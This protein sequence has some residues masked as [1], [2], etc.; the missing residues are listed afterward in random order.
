MMRKAVWPAL[1]WTAAVC[2]PALAQ[3][4]R[5]ESLVVNVEVPVRVF[6][7]SSFI[8]S[9]TAADFEVY[10]NGVPQ[11][12]EAIYMVKKRTI[13]RREEETKFKPD[14]VRNF[15]LLFEITDYVPRLDDALRYFVFDIL[16][17]GDNIILVTPLKTYRMLSEAIAAK[18][19]EDLLAQFQGILRRD[20]A[21]GT[22]EFRNIVQELERLSRALSQQVAITQQVVISPPGTNPEIPQRMDGL[23]SPE[24]EGRTIDDLLQRYSM[25][26]TQLDTIRALDPQKALDLAKHLKGVEGQKNVFLF[27][28]REFIPK[29]DPK[30]LYQYMELYQD[31]PDLQHKITELFEFY[32]RELTFNPDLIKKSFA[33]AAVSVHF[34]FLTPAPEIVTGVRLEEHSDDVYAAFREIARASGGF[35][36]SS[37][38]PALLMKSAVESSESYYLIYYSPKNY[39]RDGMFKEI[40]VRVKNSDF[41]LVHRLGYFAR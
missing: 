2:L 15:Y 13:E 10:E 40:K 27:Y 9:L 32:K 38:N 28:Q 3:Q 24:N 34:L 36:E 39:I 23:A 31:R 20:S 8:D 26:L 25:L 1:L 17:P 12:I 41:R 37:E 11:K 21:M 18:R 29:I 4:V 30:I 5:E 35:V 6:K 19:K 22:S 7:G 33:D 16:S 14:T